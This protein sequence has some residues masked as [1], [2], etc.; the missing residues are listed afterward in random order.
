MAAAAPP[1]WRRRSCEPPAGPTPPPGGLGAAAGSPHRPEG[2]GAAAGLGEAPEGWGGGGREG[3]GKGSGRGALG[4]L[5]SHGAGAVGGG[6]GPGAGAGGGVGS[7][8]L[9]QHRQQALHQGVRAGP[10]RVPP[11]GRAR[12]QQ[13]AANGRE[14]PRAGEAGVRRGEGLVGGWSRAGARWAV[15][16]GQGEPLPLRLDRVALGQGETKPKVLKVGVFGG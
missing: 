2:A 6:A 10:Q 11:P 8:H 14:G 1:P 12:R 9:P 7:A 15:P 3:S 13:H 4:R 16:G 5:R